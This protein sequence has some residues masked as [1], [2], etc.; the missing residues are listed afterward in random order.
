MLSRSL[1]IFGPLVLTLD[2]VL[3]LRGEVVLNVECLS[4]LFW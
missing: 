1:T 2:L 4:D 3:L